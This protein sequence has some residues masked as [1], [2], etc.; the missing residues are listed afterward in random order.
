MPGT[1][2]MVT[3]VNGTGYDVTNGTARY[4]SALYSGELNVRRQYSD[5]LTLLAG[6]RMVE[7][8][9]HYRGAG[10]DLQTLGQTDSILTNTFNHLYGFQIGADGEI[11]NRGGPLRINV[12]CKAGILG[13]AAYQNYHRTETTSTSTLD[14]ALAARSFAQATFLGETGLVVTYAVNKH[15]AFRGSYE[16]MWLNGV[17]LAPEQISSVNLRLGDLI[18]T[19]GGVFYHGGGLGF[20]YRF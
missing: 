1:S 8:D 15:L 4:T 17:A 20:E 9:E 2:H 11:F 16:A 10:I 3:D 13:N 7:L 18:N 12:V 19:S 5:W 6:F 14:D